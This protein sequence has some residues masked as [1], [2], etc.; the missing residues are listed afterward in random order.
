M[1]DRIVAMMPKFL[2]EQARHDIGLFEFS[3]AIKGIV[4]DHK[5]NTLRKYSNK[6]KLIP[7]V[8]WVSRVEEE[9]AIIEAIKPWPYHYQPLPEKEALDALAIAQYILHLKL[10]DS[11]A[12]VNG[13]LD[14]IRLHL[15][16]LR[17]YGCTITYRARDFRVDLDLRDIEEVVPP[18]SFL[19]ERAL[20]EEGHYQQYAEKYFAYELA[21]LHGQGKLAQ[22][23]A[24]TFGADLAQ[25]IVR[26]HEYSQA[27]SIVTVKQ[28]LVGVGGDLHVQVKVHPPKLAKATLH[29]SMVYLAALLIGVLLGVMLIARIGVGDFV[30]T[31]GLFTLLWVLATISSLVEKIKQARRI[32][33]DHEHRQATGQAR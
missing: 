12:R 30:I 19:D 4:K 31:F 11:A 5:S 2:T 8:E 21:N 7:V 10:H 20:P 16:E 32:I 22:G 9:Q 23:S 1:Q 24:I 13:D 3:S 17:D 14:M 26:L 28:S 27:E 15:A 33:K 25:L 18:P 6:V 29:R